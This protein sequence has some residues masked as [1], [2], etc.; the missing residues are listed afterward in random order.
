[1]TI[2]A[3]LKKKPV[4]AYHDGGLMFAGDEES[5]PEGWYIFIP[6]EGAF[7]VVVNV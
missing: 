2:K 7:E 6:G 3:E 5:Y 4:V 1:M